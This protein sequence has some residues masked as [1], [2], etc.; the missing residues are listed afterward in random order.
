MN[1]FF[2]KVVSHGDFVS[3][4]LP[5]VFLNRWDAWLQ[6][7][8][9]CSRER[10]GAQWLEA[11]LCS[12]IWRF[13]LAAGVCGEQG[14][15]GVMIPSV[16]RVGRYFPLTLACAGDDAPLLMRLEQD[17]LWYGRLEG[18]ALSALSE[19]FSLEVFDEAMV[20]MPSP[21]RWAPA[22][23]A[24]TV[25]A[26]PRWLDLSDPQRIG[27]GMPQLSAW[28]DPLAL[29]GHSLFWTEGSPRVA[30]SVWVGEGLPGSETFAEMLGGR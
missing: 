14:W 3:R 11:Y 25:V 28:I 2:G 12:P 21:G 15:A 23:H 29:A 7:G 19:T 13:A 10:L 26:A 8:L 30:P 24:S 6:G 9:Q 18:L 5:A 20:A 17:A 4:R 22:R 1:G 27:D 16:D